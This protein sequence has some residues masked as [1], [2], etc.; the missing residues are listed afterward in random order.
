MVRFDAQVMGCYIGASQV[1][2]IG[3][4]FWFCIPSNLSD[5][6]RSDDADHACLLV[7]ACFNACHDFIYID[8]GTRE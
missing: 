5:D 1:Y 8:I 6:S 3:N 2:F 7:V 4:K